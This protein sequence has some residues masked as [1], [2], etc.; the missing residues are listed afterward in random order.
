MVFIGTS[1]E[2]WTQ[3]TERLLWKLPPH[4][5]RIIESDDADAGPLVWTG[6][7]IRQKRFKALFR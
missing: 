2:H 1:P 7:E 6:F 3:E 5:R 4:A